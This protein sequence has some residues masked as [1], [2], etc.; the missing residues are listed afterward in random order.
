M[1]WQG[2]EFTGKRSCMSEQFDEQLR[3]DRLRITL[4]MELVT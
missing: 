2:M 1:E 4:N 3:K